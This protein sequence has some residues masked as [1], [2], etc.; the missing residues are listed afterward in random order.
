MLKS[1]I[2]SN[3]CFYIQRVTNTQNIYLYIE[4]IYALKLCK[5]L[6]AVGAQFADPR[7]RPGSLGGRSCP[8][9]RRPASASPAGTPPALVGESITE[10]IKEVFGGM[11]RQASRS[12][13]P[14]TEF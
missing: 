2:L 12:T 13:E 5:F 11:I 9:T 6:C 4:D 14:V 7:S 1:Y 8:S 3:N 10:G